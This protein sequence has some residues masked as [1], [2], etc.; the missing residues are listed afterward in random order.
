MHGPGCKDR[1]FQ[2]GKRRDERELGKVE[3]LTEKSGRE[4]G[5]WERE[6]VVNV[7]G[8]A[9][10]ARKGL[11]CTSASSQGVGGLGGQREGEQRAEG[12]KGCRARNLST[13]C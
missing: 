11:G 13:K 3:T 2:V 4:P 6:R 8:L 9:S 1:T 5:E 10:A 7:W 12:N